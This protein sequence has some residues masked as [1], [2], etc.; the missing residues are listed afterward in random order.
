VGYYLPP[1]EAGRHGRAGRADGGKKNP[2]AHEKIHH[3]REYSSGGLHAHGV[4]ACV[5][6]SG[7]Y[8]SVL[9]PAFPEQLVRVINTCDE[10]GA[11]FAADAYAPGARLARC[12]SLLRGRLKVANTT[13]EAYAEKSPVVII[14]GRAGIKDARRIRC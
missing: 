4:R 9:R 7:D 5:R 13:A 14:S 8:C 6:S 1:L 11:G 10:Q 2:P 12:A 3:H